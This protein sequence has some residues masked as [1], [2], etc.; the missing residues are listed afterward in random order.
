[1][2]RPSAENIW[3][4]RYSICASGDDGLEFGEVVLDKGIIPAGRG[5]RALIEDQNDNGDLCGWE[6]FGEDLQ[7]R[8]HARVETLA[9]HE[10]DL[11]GLVAS[12]K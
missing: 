4:V 2:R 12:W 9:E 1:M 11:F 10:T 6:N 3:I 5:R 7:T 8:E